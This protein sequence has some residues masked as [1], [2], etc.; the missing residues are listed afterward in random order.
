MFSLFSFAPWNFY[1]VAIEEGCTKVA[2]GHHA[3]DIIATFLLNLFL[4]DS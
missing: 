4:S 1:S 2:L 3:D